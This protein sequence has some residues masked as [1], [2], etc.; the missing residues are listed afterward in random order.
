MASKF[1]GWLATVSAILANT[2]TL[3]DAQG[4][5][6]VFAHFMVQLS[7]YLFVVILKL[8]LGCKGWN[9]RE[10]HCSRLGERDPASPSYWY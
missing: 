9:C 6:P 8:T 10:L 4:S 3:A 2:L 1:A 5:K 7:L